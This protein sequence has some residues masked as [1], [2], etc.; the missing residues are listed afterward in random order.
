MIDNMQHNKLTGATATEKE[1]V[2]IGKI[3]EQELRRQNRSVTWLSDSINCDRR[4]VY[5]IFRRRHLDTQLL[6]QISVV[7]GVDFFKFFSM[8]LTE[9]KDSFDTSS[10]QQS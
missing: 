7:M 10:T 6:Y 4:N 1:P 5:D 8:K 2:V 9:D 3:I